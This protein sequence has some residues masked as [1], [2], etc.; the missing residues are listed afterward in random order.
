MRISQPIKRFLR[1]PDDHYVDPEVRVHF[2]RNFITN[3][4][5]VIFW[6][7]GESFVS[8]AT[9]LPVFASSLTKSPL[10]IGLVPALINAGWVIPQI[11]MAGYVKRLGRKMPFAK[12][13]AIV[14]RLPYLI[15]PLT[16]YLLNWISGDFALIF[17]FG[18]IAWRGI[19]SGMV[20]LPWQEVIASVIPLPVRSRFFGF[21]RVFGR[22][23]GVLGSGLTSI[24]LARVS[25]PNNYALSFL[26]GGLFIWFSFF[27]FSR[28]IEPKPRKDGL[29]TSSKHQ[30]GPKRD[31]EAYKL[32]LMRDSNFRK[33]LFSRAFFQL[34]SMA[35]AFLAVHGIQRF[36]LADEQAG[37][38]SGLLF[39]SGTLG[40]VIISLVGDHAGP[41]QTLLVSDIL[42]A[43]VLLLVIFSSSIWGIYLGFLILGFAQSGYIIGEL[44]IA[45]ELGS[46]EERPIYIGLAR[47]LPGIFILISPLIGGF[48]VGQFGY[49]VMY[50]VALIFS[51]SGTLLLLGVRDRK[52]QTQA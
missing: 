31:F 23:A 43:F 36:N 19:A 51:L 40:F 37:V 22:I 46:D 16:A 24:I 42:Q 25:Y 4:V 20:A 7:F 52:N 8:V 15:L 5:D 1:L 14:E 13:M 45:L 39:L 2:R 35:I 32:I 21:S 48:L 44:I 11:L 10:L 30:S 49:R 12:A 6:L 27:F 50:F 34:G 26:I 38:F 29:E 47:S 28:T 33:Y 41:R 17:F 18:V 9:I 3:S